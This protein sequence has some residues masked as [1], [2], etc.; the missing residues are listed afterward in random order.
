MPMK[1]IYD[2]KLERVI[3]KP[4]KPREVFDLLPVP[5]IYGDQA[6]RLIEELKHEMIYGHSR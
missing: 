2:K 3:E 5:Q 1:Y 4:E 6:L